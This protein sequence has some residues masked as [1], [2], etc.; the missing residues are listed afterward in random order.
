MSVWNVGYLLRVLVC[1][2]NARELLHQSKPSIEIPHVNT[3]S[4]TCN[5]NSPLAG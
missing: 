3:L 5:P 1:L 4:G 2:V